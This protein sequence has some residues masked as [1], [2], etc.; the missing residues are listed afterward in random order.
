MLNFKNLMFVRRIR[1]YNEDNFDIFFIDVLRLLI[2]HIKIQHLE[3][4][5]HLFSQL[6]LV[7]HLP[8]LCDQRALGVHV[9]CVAQEI[10]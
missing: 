10:P 5:D 9:I 6:N 8:L 2:F 7:L 3:S 1:F 4:K